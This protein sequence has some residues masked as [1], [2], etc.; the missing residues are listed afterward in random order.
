MTVTLYKGSAPEQAHHTCFKMCLMRPLLALAKCSGTAPFRLL[1]PPYCRE[2]SPTPMFCLMY[3][4]LARDAASGQPIRPAYLMHH[5]GRLV[6]C[7][8]E[9]DR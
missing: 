4:F 2:N 7:H 5:K 1:R 6:L 9:T 8:M 3:T